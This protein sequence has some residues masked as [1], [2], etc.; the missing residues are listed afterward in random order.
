MA[1]LVEKVYGEGMRKRA[2][3]ALAGHEAK[4]ELLAGSASTLR[5]NGAVQALDVALRK[6]RQKEKTG[7]GI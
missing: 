7:H 2:A 6:L 4:R 1:V 5:Q 3:E